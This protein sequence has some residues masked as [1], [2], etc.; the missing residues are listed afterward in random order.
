MVVLHVIFHRIEDSIKIYIFVLFAY[1]T[2][3]YG[4]FLSLLFNFSSKVKIRNNVKKKKK[5][6]I[7][8]VHCPTTSFYC[9]LLPR[10]IGILLSAIS[11]LKYSSCKMN[12][13][14]DYNV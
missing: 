5:D 2:F 1:P 12:L 6:G 11:I 3:S 14:K 9:E 4:G 10:V 8:L 7:R 13:Y